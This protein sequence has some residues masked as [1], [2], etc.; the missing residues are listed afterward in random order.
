[1]R[2]SPHFTLRELTHSE[3]AAR[4]GVDNTPPSSAV[5]TLERLANEVLEPLRTAIGAPL[6]ITSGYR[7]L[8]VNAM[9]GGALRSA[10]LDGRAA[11]FV[12]IG[13]PL[14]EAARRARAACASL[15][16][17][18]LILEFGRWIHV[19]VE[20]LGVLPRRIY[21]T[22]ESSAQGTVYREWHA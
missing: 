20:P 3:W 1:M 14:E 4:H 21:L 15:P 2:L 22:A 10:H 18:K 5:H 9:V 12:P 16:V 13:V 7:S 6:F 11:D 8:Q 17:G 19:Q